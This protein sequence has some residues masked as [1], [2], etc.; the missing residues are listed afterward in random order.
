MAIAFRE[1]QQA[2]TTNGA[3]PSIT[4][5]TLVSG[6][7]VFL[8]TCSNDSDAQ[9][10]T[11]DG[12]DNAATVIDNSS[13]IGD[14]DV[15]AMVSAFLFAGGSQVFRVATAGTSGFGLTLGGIAVSGLDVSN[16]AGFSYLGG[17]GANKAKVF[18]SSTNPDPPSVNMTAGNW[19]LV[20]AGSTNNDAA[21]TLP[22]G[23]TNEIDVAADAASADASLGMGT[24]LITA[25]GAENPAAFGSW[26]TGSW[27][28]FTIELQEAPSG[29]PYIK[30]AGGVPWMAGGFRAPQGGR[31]WMPHR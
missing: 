7:V 30:R 19:S 10:Y 4:F 21:K 25:T 23:Y 27:G 11:E 17:S 5:T 9:L 18:G 1:L 6:D 13:L 29:Q 28:A 26:A 22:T 31:L 24:K 15:Y 2:S 16:F 12:N 3:V 8:G 14:D 20:V